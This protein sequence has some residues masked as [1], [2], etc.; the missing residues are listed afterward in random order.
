[1]KKK[2][3]LVL[4]STFPRWANDSTSPFVFEL[5][6]R[7]V[8]D[9]NIHILAPHAFGAK[10]E[11]T[12]EGLHVHRFQYWWPAKLQ[13]LSYNGGILPNLK[14]NPFLIAQM[15]T[16]VS[17][18]FIAAI[19]LIM[20]HRIDL[21]HVHWVIPYGLIALIIKIIF[22][23]PYIVT[24]HGSDIYGLRH[25]IFTFLKKIFFE[26]SKRVIVV[27]TSLKQE[28]E[29]SITSKPKI[30]VISMGV[31][32]KL[33]SPS[34]HDPKLRKK[35]NI[36]G[37]FLLFVGRL[38]AVKGVK[39]LISAMPPIIKHNRETKLVIVGYGP[40]ENELKQLTKKMELEQNII[41]TGPIQNSELPKYYA[42]ADMFI[43][44]SIMT[45]EKQTEGFGLTFV[46]AALSGTIPIG[47]VVGGIPDIIQNGR[48]GVLIREKDTPA[49]SDAVINLLQDKQLSDGIKSQARKIV[50]QSYDWKIIVNKYKY[51]YIINTA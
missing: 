26:N 7:L 43:G 1:M 21:I 12:M 10:K 13:K 28:V 27:S 14:K 35:L 49:I 39:Y 16:L 44:P 22:G 46:E 24:S 34:K 33:F 45:I 15:F 25:E 36:K 42:T 18:E 41:F 19:K 23:T 29:F 38:M 47:T 8:K 51:E 48:T 31:D 6:K 37:P 40:L 3:V 9:F 17:F 32:S 20:Q 11:E 4:A 5:E 50:S 30:E 2:N